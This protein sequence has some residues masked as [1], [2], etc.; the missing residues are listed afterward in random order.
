MEREWTLGAPVA[1]AACDSHVILSVRSSSASVLALRIGVEERTVAPGQDR[2][3]FLPAGTTW[4][5]QAIGG[6]VRTGLM[7][8]P[9]ALMTECGGAASPWRVAI[10]ERK[11]RLAE[12]ARWLGQQDAIGLRRADCLMQRLLARL[13]ASSFGSLERRPDDAWLPAATL[14]RMPSAVTSVGLDRM[15]LEALASEA[16]LGISAFARGFR[17]STGWTPGD[18]LIALRMKQVASLLATTDLPMKEIARHVGLRSAAHAE[19]QFRRSHGVTTKTFRA[20]VDG[21]PV[22]WRAT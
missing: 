14:A 12:A 5:A 15:S 6:P 16:G 1:S 8:I 2:I 17:G 21:D 3:S 9:I 19:Q 13:A 7:S 4:E 20:A 10:G 22:L 18:Y 11:P